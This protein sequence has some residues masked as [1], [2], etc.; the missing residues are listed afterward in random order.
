M[1]LAL[2]GGEQDPVTPVPELR[3]WNDLVS[4][5]ADTQLF[6]GGH[7]YLQ[8]GTKALVDHLTGALDT[9]LHRPV[10]TA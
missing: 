3:A 9:V 2:Y 1:P 7:T 8:T 4:T 6:P 10:A 5:P